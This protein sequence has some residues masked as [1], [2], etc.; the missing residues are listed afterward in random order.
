MYGALH[1]PFV[2]PQSSGQNSSSGGT[3]DLVASFRSF[4]CMS[5]SGSHQMT[6]TIERNDSL[7]LLLP[8]A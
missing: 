5:Q 7:L 8:N 1:L 4:L 2:I 6:M 3:K